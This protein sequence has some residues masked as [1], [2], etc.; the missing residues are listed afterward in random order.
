MTKSWNNWSNSE[1]LFSIISIE[2]R[3]QKG[4]CASWE[5]ETHALLAIAHGVRTHAPAV[6]RA[7]AHVRMVHLMMRLDLPM[8]TMLLRLRLGE[9]LTK[10]TS[11]FGWW[12]LSLLLLVAGTL[13]A[14]V[15]R[16]GNHTVVP[17]CSYYGDYIEQ[18]NNEVSLQ[19]RD[20]LYQ[21]AFKRYSTGEEQ[22]YHKAAKVVAQLG[23][24]RRA[25][26]YL[27]NEVAP[28]PWQIPVILEDTLLWCYMR[29]M[30]KDSLDKAW[31]PK[32]DSYVAGLN[33]GLI[34]RLNNLGTIDQYVRGIF[35]PLSTIT[36]VDTS[37]LV[38][39]LWKWIAELDSMKESIA[40]SIITALGR[41][42][43]T[44]IIGPEA[45]KNMWL[46]VTHSD[47]TFQK[48]IEPLMR[49]SCEQGLTPWKYYAFVADR[50]EVK[51]EAHHTRYGCAM[52]N[53]PDRGAVMLPWDPQCVNYLRESIGL[54][55]W[56]GFDNLGPCPKDNQ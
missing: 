40:D 34:R 44:D 6:L 11:K 29:D 54:P 31:K 16:T 24:Y 1:G 39:H 25:L 17:C 14:Q 22:D 13:A 46:C 30:L 49:A 19:D 23:D 36:S 53:F 3:L 45:S 18:A 21:K 2:T 7:A 52:F 35:A 38:H 20:Q 4:K 32:Y 28:R 5:V 55:P 8:M 27:N 10:P 42:P 48:Q 50:I 15:E 47:T 9:L 51:R 56:H 43:G 12:V 37:R 26:L 41:Y 33:Q